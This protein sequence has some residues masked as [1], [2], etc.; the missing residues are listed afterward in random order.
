LGIKRLVRDVFGLTG[1]VETDAAGQVCRIIL[2]QAHRRA[3]RL[4][5]AFQSLLAPGH[6]VL[7]LG[8]T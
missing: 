5:T 1:A 2:N 4:L 7:I 6:V 8:E 3:H